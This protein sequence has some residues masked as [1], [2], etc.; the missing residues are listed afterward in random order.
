MPGIGWECQSKEAKLKEIVDK[1]LAVC[2]NSHKCSKCHKPF[3]YGDT[4]TKVS[5]NPKAEKI[6]GE[7][8]SQQKPKCSSCGNTTSNGLGSLCD[9]DYIGETQR[10]CANCWLTKCSSEAI[11]FLEKNKSQQT[12]FYDFYEKTNKP[13]LMNGIKEIKDLEA[14][15]RLEKAFND[16]GECGRS[17]VIINPESGL[18]NSCGMAKLRLMIQQMIREEGLKEGQIEWERVKPQIEQ[19]I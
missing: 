13:L 14:K 7:E 1:H 6:E 8:E 5:N 15:R 19:M 3:S 16:L 17:N 12:R 4:Y 10:I 9:E 2:S 18:C 11:D